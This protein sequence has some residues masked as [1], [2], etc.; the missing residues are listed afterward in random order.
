M[1]RRFCPSCGTAIG[2]EIPDGLMAVQVGTMDEQTMFSPKVAI[3]TVDQ[4]TLHMIPENLKSFK[5]MPE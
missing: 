3:F 4:Q 1:T 5:R 2:T